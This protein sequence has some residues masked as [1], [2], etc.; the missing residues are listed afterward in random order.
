MNLAN[1]ATIPLA[2]AGVSTL[3]TIRYVA[4]KRRV[5]DV[6]ITQIFTATTMAIYQF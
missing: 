2:L 1:P 4:R 3:L 6:S 5:S